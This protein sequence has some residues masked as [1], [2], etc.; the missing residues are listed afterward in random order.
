MVVQESTVADRCP[1]GDEESDTFEAQRDPLGPTVAAYVAW[2]VLGFITGGHWLVIAYHTEKGKRWRPVMHFVAVVFM[3][4]LFIGFR[5]PLPSWSEHC[6][7][8]STMSR[9]CLFH[10]QPAKYAVFYVTHIIILVFVFITYFI[11]GAQLWWWV[12]AALN[13]RRKTLAVCC[14]ATTSKSYMFSYVISVA[15]TALIIVIWCSVN[16]KIG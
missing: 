16:W 14:C 8:G 12:Q 2:L 9:D 6:K 11:E 3:A 4:L 13:N 1:V 5:W 10:D 15:L 7:D